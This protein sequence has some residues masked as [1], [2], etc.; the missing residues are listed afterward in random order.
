MELEFVKMSRPADETIIGMDDGEKLYY[1]KPPEPLISSAKDLL[2]R[3]GPPARGDTKLAIVGDRPGDLSPK[4]R[5]SLWMLW[6]KFSSLLYLLVIL[7]LVLWALHQ[8]KQ[9]QGEEESLYQV[10]GLFSLTSPAGKT[11]TRLGDPAFIRSHDYKLRKLKLKI[12]LLIFLMLFDTV[13]KK[14]RY[15]NIQFQTCC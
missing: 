9:T 15:E 4:S 8:Y 5:C 10:R 12:G 6:L 7:M 3:Q 1:Q 14:C 13:L 11:C 2:T